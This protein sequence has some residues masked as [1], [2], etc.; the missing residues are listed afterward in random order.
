MVDLQDLQTKTL[1]K[2]KRRNYER[3]NKFQNTEHNVFFFAYL[4]AEDK[5]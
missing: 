5:Q 3:K 2:N 4:N 1:L